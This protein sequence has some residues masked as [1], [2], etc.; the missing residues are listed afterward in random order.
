MGLQD[1]RVLVVGASSGI[2]RAV[3]LQAVDAGARVVL[4]ARRADK[5]AEAAAAAGDRA[6]TAVCDVRDPGQCH[7]VVRDAVAQLRGLDVVVY[8]TAIDPLVRLVDTDAE[9][10]RAVFETNVF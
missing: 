3:A 4:A 1:V 5:L 10:W 9:R 8:A 6:S 7:A 2:G